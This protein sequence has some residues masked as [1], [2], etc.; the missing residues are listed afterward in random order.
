MPIHVAI[1]RQVRP[2]REQEFQA[3]LREFLQASFQHSS[4]QGASM[5]VPPSDSG[6]REYGILRTFS[7]EAEMDGFYQSALFR[8]WDERARTMTEGD[9]VYRQLHGLEG[10]FR[11]PGSP[12]PRWKM[13]CAT[14]LGVFPL[15]MV[16]NLTVGPVIR[17]WPFVLSNAAFNACVVAS[18]TWIV[19]PVVTRLLH[20][21]LH[22]HP[23][24][25]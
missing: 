6:S 19:M 1:T 25:Q 17:S 8:K 23:N 4:V 15:A 9:P 21:W 24:R 10:W 7:S 13:A 3:A 18:L 12:P 22:P 2:G 16:L 14:F 11:S 5:L 20:G